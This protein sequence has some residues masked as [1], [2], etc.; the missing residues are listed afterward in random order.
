MEPPTMAPLAGER[1]LERLPL[2]AEWDGGGDWIDV[3]EV[4]EG[5]DEEGCDED[6][7]EGI[8]EVVEDGRNS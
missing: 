4:E 6:A 3:P 5:C 8:E 7:G 1:E 2:L